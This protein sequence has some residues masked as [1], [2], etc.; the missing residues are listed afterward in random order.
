[1]GQRRVAAYQTQCVSTAQVGRKVLTGYEMTGSAGEQR[2]RYV[3]SY[4]L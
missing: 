2:Q 3:E 4:H 1:M